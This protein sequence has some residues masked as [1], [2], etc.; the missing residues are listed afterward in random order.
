MTSDVGLQRWAL[1]PANERVSITGSAGH[2]GPALECKG[3]PRTRGQQRLSQTIAASF[4]ARLGRFQARSC[5]SARHGRPL[6]GLPAAANPHIFCLNAAERNREQNVS[7]RGQ[8]NVF[9]CR[10]LPICDACVARLLLRGK[11]LRGG[12]QRLVLLSRKNQPA[13]AVKC[14]MLSSAVTRAPPAPSRCCTLQRMPAFSWWKGVRWDHVPY[15]PH[16]AARVSW[17]C[18]PSGRSSQV[19]DSPRR[20]PGGITAGLHRS[21]IDEST[22]HGCRCRSLHGDRRRGAATT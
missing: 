21:V 10:L 4:K 15:K 20:E 1:L 22:P 2:A 14:S 16:V 18:C 8:S 12:L 5:C 17:P 11:G 13:H 7:G 3:L 19:T 6:E 9:A